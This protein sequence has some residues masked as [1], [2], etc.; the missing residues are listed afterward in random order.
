[1]RHLKKGRKFGRTSA[2]RRAMYRNMAISL[3]R[4]ER[5]ET[6]AAKAKS[7]R[8]FAERLITLAKRGDLHARR[9]AARDIRD[10]EVLQKLFDDL[11]ERFRERPGGYTRVLKT[12]FRRG[13]NSK[14]ALIEL[15]DKAPADSSDSE[16]A[17]G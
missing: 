1:M 15:V 7:L 9:L 17:A 11:A 3:F 4:H 13:D 16:A 12:G 8:G 14:T 6:T 2:H 5:I 10:H